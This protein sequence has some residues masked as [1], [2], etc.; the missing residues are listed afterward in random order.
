MRDLMDRGARF[1]V[2]CLPSSEFASAHFP[3]APV[4][5]SG[6]LVVG[7]GESVLWER[8]LHLAMDVDLFEQ[9][10]GVP[11]LIDACRVTGPARSRSKGRTLILRS[12]RIVEACIREPA[13]IG[14]ER[15]RWA[16]TLLGSGQI[17]DLACVGLSTREDDLSYLATWY[18]HFGIDRASGSFSCI[19]TCVNGSESLFSLIVGSIPIWQGDASSCSFRRGGWRGRVR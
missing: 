14:I 10:H 9:T 18:P 1:V 15:L 3:D 4:V 17:A 7:E 11:L 13:S 8:D 12:A 2:S 16:M 6:E 5:G 19:P